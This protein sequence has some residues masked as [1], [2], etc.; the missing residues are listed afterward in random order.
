LS[1]DPDK[2]TD[3]EAVRSRVVAALKAVR[4]PELPVNIYELGLVYG[5]DIDAHGDV[6]IRMTLTT[7]NCPVAGELPREVQTKASAV[8]GVRD[9]KVDIV[10]EPPWTP[11]RMSEA[12][13]LEMNLDDGVWPP[14]QKKS[15]FTNLGRLK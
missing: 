14:D 15:K 13:K 1:T 10:W 5:I 9:V 3:I 11:D 4:D 2:P 8:E 6:H 7:P 12:A